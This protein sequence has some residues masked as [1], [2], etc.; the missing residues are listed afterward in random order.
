MK[1]IGTL[2]NEELESIKGSQETIRN[3][4]QE[5]GHL[6]FSKQIALNKLAKVKTD[7]AVVEKALIDKFGEKAVVN[8]NTGKV[9]APK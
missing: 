8:T 2:T 1:E 5:V 3:L 6:E 4:Y 9:S 7:M